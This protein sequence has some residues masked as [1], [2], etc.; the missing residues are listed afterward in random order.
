M[1]LLTEEKSTSTH[2]A[3]LLA[4]PAE[5]CC[6]ELARLGWWSRLGGDGK[7]GNWMHR[8]SRS[9]NEGIQS[10]YCKF[11]Y[12]YTNILICYIYFYIYTV[13]IRL[14]SI[15]IFILSKILCEEL[16]MY[17]VRDKNLQYLEIMFWIKK[18]I[19]IRLES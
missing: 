14:N 4:L 17:I 1:D 6:L 7:T 13:T 18:C 12:L 5:H 9:S 2:V 16:E 8:K 15:F 19:K 10:S 11:V 3:A